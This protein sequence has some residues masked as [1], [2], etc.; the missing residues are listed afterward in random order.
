[1]EDLFDKFLLSEI[2]GPIDFQCS[3][4]SG[5]P[6]MNVRK[7]VKSTGQRTRYP[8]QETIYIDFF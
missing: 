5:S 4:A 1:M 2:N 8:I 7:N 6:S 3:S